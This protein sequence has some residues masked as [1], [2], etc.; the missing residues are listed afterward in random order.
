MP[1]ARIIPVKVQM[2][3]GAHT[4]RAFT[5]K[6]FTKDGPSGITKSLDN[7]GTSYVPHGD[8]GSKKGGD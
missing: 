6:S 1:Q 5:P 7:N 2:G 4:A 3:E 8:G